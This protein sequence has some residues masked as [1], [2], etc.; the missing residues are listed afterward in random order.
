M[1]DFITLRCPLEG[2][3]SNETVLDVAHIFL[4]VLTL[5]V[6]IYTKFLPKKDNRND[7]KKREKKRKKNKKKKERK[8]AALQK[9][10]EDVKP[11]TMLY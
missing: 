2:L 10:Y 6:V 5:F 8:N 4:E 3:A 1:L 11:K 9:Y 7:Q